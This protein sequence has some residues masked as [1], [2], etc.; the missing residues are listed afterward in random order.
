[1]RNTARVIDDDQTALDRYRRISMIIRALASDITAE[2]IASIVVRQG[3][4]GLHASGAGIGF[5]AG[6]RL[7]RVAAVGS[8][9]TSIQRV[10]SRSSGLR[11]DEQNP[12]CVAIRTDEEV[13]IT[14]RDTGLRQFPHLAFASSRSQGW[15]ALPLKHQ[16]QTF[17]AFSLSFVAP[18]VFGAADREFVSALGD[19]AALALAPIH[20]A[21]ARSGVIGPGGIGP[22]PAEQRTVDSLGIEPP[23]HP[24]SEA[25]VNARTD[26]LVAVDT[27]GTIVQCNDRL[28]ELLG[29]EAGQ[30]IGRSIEVLLPP[31]RREEHIRQR[32]R[33]IEDPVPRSERSGLD[34]VALRADG[35]ELPVDVTLSP[36][37]TSS[38]MRTF[39]VV[40]PR[41]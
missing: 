4:A 24:L 17:G 21:S 41:R 27:G 19:V 16:G 10:W 14:D 13:W 36:C 29:Y 8:T 2:E 22:R 11:L 20:Q 15:V 34:L 3:M 26:G 31:H 33:Y 39:A 12:S 35:T 18:P 32:R 9:A 23:A 30:L 5:L 37:T 28:C 6:D 38:G 25:L 40:R 1:M 7:Y